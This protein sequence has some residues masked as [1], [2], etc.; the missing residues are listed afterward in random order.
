MNIYNTPYTYLIGWSNQN[1]YYY[2]VRYAKDCHPND[3]WDKYFTSSNFVKELRETCGEPDLIQIRRTFDTPDQAIAWETKV[4]KR[5]NVLHRN[6][7]LNQNIAGTAVMTE[8]G[9][10]KVSATHKGKTISAETKAKMSIARKQWLKHNQDPNVGK[11]ISDETRA[12]LSAAKKGKKRSA[13]TIAKMS[14]GLK[15]HYRRKAL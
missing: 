7:F 12:K 5:M 4:L 3:F 9:K 1:K 2:G 11:Q 10:S 14:A 15:E 6:D 13:E 8:Q